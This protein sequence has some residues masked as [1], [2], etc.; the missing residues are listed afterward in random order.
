MEHR[1]SEIFPHKKMY[2]TTE[3]LFLVYVKLYN[4]FLC[5]KT[6]QRTGCS[7]L[8]CMFFNSYLIYVLSEA[9]FLIRYC[10][11]SVSDFCGYLV[12][13]SQIFVIRSNESPRSSE[14][15]SGVLCFVRY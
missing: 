7:V 3:N 10:A 14:M 12:S 15:A 5:R 8:G 6:E 11:I 13:R 4:A 1:K 9:V 2:D